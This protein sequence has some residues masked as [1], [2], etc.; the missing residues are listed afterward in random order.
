[1]ISTDPPP[2]PAPAATTARELWPDPVAEEGADTEHRLVET[3]TTTQLSPL[4]GVTG[5]VVGPAHVGLAGQ[6]HA[7]EGAAPCFVS[8]HSVAAGQPARR[9]PAPWA[10]WPAPVHLGH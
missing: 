5:Q 8:L 6:L 9:E 2:A 10:L 4:A 7:Y 3:V 1:M